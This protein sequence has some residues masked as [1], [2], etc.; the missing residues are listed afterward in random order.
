MPNQSSI[1]KGLHE[2]NKFLLKS[3]YVDTTSERGTVIILVDGM[4][5]LAMV[6]NDRS[7]AKL[8]EEQKEI[9]G[10]PIKSTNA[11]KFVF[12]NDQCKETGEQ[13]DQEQEDEFADLYKAMDVHELT[14]QE[15]IYIKRFEQLGVWRKK[16]TE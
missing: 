7:S 15:L 11:P 3:G 14:G 13:V 5:Q 12:L 1:V 6:H 8:T 16:F 9:L 10:L 4:D 2:R